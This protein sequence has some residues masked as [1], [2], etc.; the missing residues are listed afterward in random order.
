VLFGAFKA[1]LKK[2]KPQ[3]VKSL[4]IAWRLLGQAWS[5]VASVGVSV[6]A[7]ESTGVNPFNL[8]RVRKHVFSISDTCVTLTSKETA[9]SNNARA[10]KTCYLSQQNL[11]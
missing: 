6:S 9:L 11:H 5:K 10:V 7:Y 8:S 3:L 2:K 1:L 4:D